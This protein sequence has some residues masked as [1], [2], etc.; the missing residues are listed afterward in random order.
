MVLYCAAITSMDAAGPKVLLH[1][2]SLADQVQAGFVLA[3]VPEPIA[4]VLADSGYSPAF[5]VFADLAEA[6]AAV[7]R[8]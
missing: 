4:E 7:S 8:R 2:S 3:E 5:T 1:A 6:K